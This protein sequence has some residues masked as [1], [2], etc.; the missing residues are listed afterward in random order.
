MYVHARACACMHVHSFPT[1]FCIYLSLGL[2]ALS[3]VLLIKKVSLIVNVT[4]FNSCWPYLSQLF[5]ENNLWIVCHASVAKYYN[6]LPVIKN[7]HPVTFSERHICIFTSLV[8]VHSHH[9]TAPLLLRNCDKWTTLLTSSTNNAHAKSS[10]QV[11]IIINR[12]Q[13]KHSQ[14]TLQWK[15][16]E[17]GIITI[18]QEWAGKYIIW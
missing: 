3:F 7:L 10:K 1:L 14:Q 11:H 2:Y 18:W 4:T 15:T 9:H 12:G 8:V 16:W 17:L 5:T 6:V 13:H